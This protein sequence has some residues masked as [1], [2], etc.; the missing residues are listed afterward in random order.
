MSRLGRGQPFR[1]QLVT[2][3]VIA[4]GTASPSDAD[5]ASSVDTNA[6]ILVSVSSPDTGTGTEAVASITVPVSGSDTGSGA[7]GTPS[8][9]NAISSSD[10]TSGA[11]GA[12]YASTTTTTDT[13]SGGEGASLGV[14]SSDSGTGSEGNSIAATVTDSDAN[15]VTIEVGT[16]P[17]AIFVDS[18]GSFNN[19][20]A[21]FVHLTV[22]SGTQVGDL[23]LAVVGDVFSGSAS[24]S[25]ASGW[26]SRDATSIGSANLA[27]GLYYRVADATDVATLPTYDFPIGGSHKAIGIIASFN[28]VDTN[29]PFNQHTLTTV[30][31][32]S[33][34]QP[35]ASVTPTVFN[36]MLVGFGIFRNNANGLTNNNTTVPSGWTER[37]DVQTTAASSNNAA[38]V[39]MTQTQVNPA[40]P[41]SLTATL[42]NS[43]TGI[44][45]TL[46]LTPQPSPDT[47]T[48]TEGVPKIALSGAD[49][50]TFS[51]TAVV[52][53]SLSSSDTGHGTDANLPI[54]VP[55]SSSDTG[56]GADGTPLFSKSDADAGGAGAGFG[57]SGYG[58]GTFGLGTNSETEHIDA[59]VSA[60]DSGTG[61]ESQPIRTH[62]TSVPG[63]PNSVPTFLV[64]GFA[65]ND[66]LS[67]NGVPVQDADFGS[68]VEFGSATGNSVSQ[69]DSGS[70][71]EAVTIGI[72]SADTGHLTETVISSGSPVV[73]IT[74]FDR[75]NPSDSYIT[76]ET[77]GAAG[78]GSG[79]FGG[80]TPAPVEQV[81][82]IALNSTDHGTASESASAP[83]ITDSAHSTESGTIA[84]NKG[85]IDHFVVAE[86]AIVVK[87]GSTSLTGSDTGTFTEAASVV[88]VSG[89]SS[90]DSGHGTE[91][92][93]PAMPLTNTAGMEI[94]N[95]VEAW[96]VIEVKAPPPPVTQP[97]IGWRYQRA[98]PTARAFSASC[99]V[100]N[101]MIVMGGVGS[102][103]S[104]QKNEI[105]DPYLQ[106]WTTGADVPN[107]RAYSSAAN[108]HGKVYLISGL[109][110]DSS[111]V[112]ATDIY[113][114]L[115]NSWSIGPACPQLYG[116]SA[117]A[118]QDKQC[119]YIF[120]GTL[121][122]T[123]T[124]LGDSV[125]RNIVWPITRPLRGG[126]GG[127]HRAE[128]IMNTVFKF[129]ATTYT[130]AGNT[131]V[132]M[133]FHGAARVG[134]YF[135]MAGG[136][137][138]L[139]GTGE[140]QY[141]NIA[142]QSATL[143]PN[144]NIDSYITASAIGNVVYFMGGGHFQA[145][146]ITSSSQTWAYDTVLN[147]WFQ[148]SNFEE[149]R[150]GAVSTTIDLGAR[151]AMSFPRITQFSGT[152]VSNDL[153][154]MFGGEEL[155]SFMG[156]N[157]FNPSNAMQIYNPKAHSM[158]ALSMPISLDHVTS[159]VVN[160]AIY[161]GG[162]NGL[163][164][165]WL[166]FQPGM[167]TYTVLP[168][169]TKLKQGGG[170]AAIGNLI[171]FVPNLNAPG[172]VMRIYDTVG[173]TWFGTTSSV[174]I[175]GIDNLDMI[176]NNGKLYL[177][178]ADRVWS[179]DPGT[180][181]WTSMNAAGITDPQFRCTTTQNKI[182]AISG[183]L[184]E[185]WE[186]DIPT[187]SWR[188]IRELNSFRTH[189]TPVY[190]DEGNLYVV[191]GFTDPEQPGDPTPDLSDAANNEVFR[192]EPAL[193]LAGG[194]T[195][196]AD[197]SGAIV[198]SS[199][200]EASGG[201]TI[202]DPLTRI[203]SAFSFPGGNYFV[204][205]LENL[206]LCYV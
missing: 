146:T 139:S 162:A 173:H 40:A 99:N 83:D 134:D 156:L 171:Y 101:Q 188:F 190:D 37:V 177:I 21:S 91:S 28:N 130:S 148:S 172:A 17:A 43:S 59:F 25:A 7:E 1:P 169:I 181:I 153:I 66:F 176:A 165:V 191:G 14:S 97:T 200:V 163:S 49:V 50:G 135:Y 89:I 93:N 204:D 122:G 33:T 71:T 46:A 197:D 79:S 120:G 100:R 3:Q 108:I 29:N 2:P 69:S 70:F 194:A 115:N 105:F 180:D 107:P 175:S 174:P 88:V 94:G 67:I 8:I 81:V 111:P 13:G 198:Y 164:G 152:Q 65:A 39:F 102:V 15:G 137:G 61:L 121:P 186:F 160:N 35:F 58:G 31:T 116:H 149:N 90:S 206:I 127:G 103:S 24:T 133:T 157:T 106:V 199:T 4:A 38:A 12:T 145:G 56:A 63:T 154:Y 187:Q 142:N 183:V 19:T 30:T 87:T 64:P 202:N 78:Y 92:Q 54:A 82:G 123:G 118:H 119:I 182:V 179:Y 143:A 76:G 18:T 77:Y 84:A 203:S 44:L 196:D 112:T 205:D 41:S 136:N 74:D 192:S 128:I 42:Q 98:M 132:N 193:F 10:N 151:P 72:S 23:M 110:L 125:V 155:T 126:P 104:Y 22:P 57:G 86:D 131:A 52:T 158:I 34:S 27:A 36:D 129:D 62:F 20:G 185:H 113:D 178:A 140:A 80:T 138:G 167:N 51:E 144:I 26:T 75:N 170:V 168:T 73:L 195:A 11:E 5:T 48:G 55:V 68:A 47:G 85:A 147:A 150:T 141:W 53:I 117:V 45:F 6:T 161:I 60:A 159:C 32:T 9:A 189:S 166:K 16:L 96:N 95:F 109:G 124:G 114:P 201:I 184:G